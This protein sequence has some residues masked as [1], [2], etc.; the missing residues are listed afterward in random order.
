MNKSK[1]NDH[2]IQIFCIIFLIILAAITT[3]YEKKSGY[4]KV[5]ERMCNNGS[6]CLEYSWGPIKKD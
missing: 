2:I 3:D 1:E 5:C 6:S 4:G